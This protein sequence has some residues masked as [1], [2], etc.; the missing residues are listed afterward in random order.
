MWYELFIGTYLLKEPDNIVRQPASRKQGVKP[1]IK[2]SSQFL[3]MRL[4]SKC[5][6]NIVELKFV[7]S[8]PGYSLALCAMARASGECGE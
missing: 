2:K 4:E 3:R 7:Y 6:W 5:N 8:P 1:Y